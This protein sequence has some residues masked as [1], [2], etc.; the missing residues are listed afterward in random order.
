MQAP[1]RKRNLHLCYDETWGQT[2]KN[3]PR[4]SSIYF[5]FQFVLVMAREP[6]A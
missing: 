3:R 2:Q 4:V 6:L 1:S 5:F